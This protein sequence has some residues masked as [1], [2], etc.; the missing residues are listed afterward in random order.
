MSP[1][2]MYGGTFDNT[3]LQGT[4]NKETGHSWEKKN[5]FWNISVRLMVSYHWS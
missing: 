2:A 1:I 4:E 5:H 3:L